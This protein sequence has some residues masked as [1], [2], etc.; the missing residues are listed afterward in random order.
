MNL[1]VINTN[2][3]ASHISDQRVAKQQL[4]KHG[5]A[6]NNRWGYVFYVGRA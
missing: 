5:P 6:R 4:C 1:L 2:I 3:T